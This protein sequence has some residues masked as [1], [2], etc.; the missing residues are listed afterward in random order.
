MR[1]PGLKI[2]LFFTFATAA[3]HANAQS[4]D[5]GLVIALDRIGGNLLGTD[6]FDA[7]LQSPPEPVEPER[8]RV[9]LTPSATAVEIVVTR[10]ANPP[11]PVAGPPSETSPPDPVRAFFRMTVGGSELMKLEFD[12]SPGEII[13]CVL[14]EDL[15]DIAAAP[16][17][18]GKGA[19]SLRPGLV[20]ALAEVGA[21][22]LGAGAFDAV[23][24]APP[25]PIVPQSLRLFVS[26]T[27]QIEF[28]LQAPPD[29]VHALARIVVGGPNM[30][31]WFDPAVGR[32][33][34]EHRIHQSEHS[35]PEI[36]DGARESRW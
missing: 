31:I 11:E 20:T 10:L 17:D 23:L 13:P 16:A 30:Q 8:L 3:T 33:R 25:D 4:L 22:L 26:K 5:R 35:D 29:P 19:R 9:Y 6:A 36:A 12:P 14:P 21:N 15:S 28:V 27:A 2:A 24:N 1:H 7:V 32:A 34:A 18:T